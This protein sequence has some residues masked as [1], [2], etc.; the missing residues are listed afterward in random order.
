M[1]V[2]K[3][4]ILL[5]CDLAKLGANTVLQLQG[6]QIFWVWGFIELQAWVGPGLEKLSFWGKNSLCLLYRIHFCATYENLF[7]LSFLENW[8]YAFMGLMIMQCSP[9]FEP[10]GLWVCA[11]YGFLTLYCPHHPDLL[12]DLTCFH[13][14]RARYLDQLSLQTTLDTSNTVNLP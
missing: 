6:A 2:M 4:C 1:F 7:Q 13:K 8:A 14:S 9:G 10:A 5:H 11:I 12:I 3:S